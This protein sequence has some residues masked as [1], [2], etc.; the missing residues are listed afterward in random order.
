MRFFVETVG[1]MGLTV[2]AHLVVEYRGRKLGKLPIPLDEAQAIARDCPAEMDSFVCPK[3][4][5]AIRRDDIPLHQAH[6]QDPPWNTGFEWCG[7]CPACDK[8]RRLSVNRTHEECAECELER[9]W[10][11]EC[12]GHEAGPVRCPNFVRKGSA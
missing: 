9:S 8:K 6:E 4:G 7:S 1:D 5:N 12:S 3:C 10:P 11:P 2:K